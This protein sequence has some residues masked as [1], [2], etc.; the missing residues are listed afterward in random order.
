MFNSAY[1]ATRVYRGAEPALE[2]ACLALSEHLVGDDR[3][4]AFRRLASRL[5]IDAVKLHRLMKRLPDEAPDP[6]REDRR[7]SLGV[8]HALRLALMQHMFLRAVQIP[9]FS[10]SNDISREDVLGMIFSLRIDDAV[11]QLRRAFPVAEPAIADFA[12]DEPSDYPDGEAQAYA[13][14]Q[15]AYIDPIAQAHAL[16]LRI[17]T[18][19]ANHFG[20]HG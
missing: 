5:R 14:I 17:G 13:G 18:A 4:G 12:V 2:D 16:T 3:T 15:V 8:L 9:A 20:A 7:R 19:I 1:W 6:L 10:R 11:T